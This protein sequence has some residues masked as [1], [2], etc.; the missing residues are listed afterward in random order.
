MNM[1]IWPFSLPLIVVSCRIS[2]KLDESKTGAGA[3]GS[4]IPPTKT[5]IDA[6]MKETLSAAQREQD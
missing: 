1:L 3:P 5:R 4:L 6:N 2:E